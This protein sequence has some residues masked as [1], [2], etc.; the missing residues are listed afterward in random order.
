MNT[1]PAFLEGGVKKKKKKKK[2][3]SSSSSDDSVFDSSDSSEDVEDFSGSGTSYTVT[4]GEL[5]K[6]HQ[7]RLDAQNSYHN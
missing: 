1:T 4:T 7:D 5:Q 6:I 2:D 3:S